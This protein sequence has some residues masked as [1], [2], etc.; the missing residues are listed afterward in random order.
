[1]STI[2]VTGDAGFIVSHLCEPLLRLGTIYSGPQ[3]I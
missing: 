3:I 2:L 1:M